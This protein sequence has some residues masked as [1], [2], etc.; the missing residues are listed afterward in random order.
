MVCGLD[1]MAS[2]VR[3]AA[4]I[5]LRVRRARVSVCEYGHIANVSTPERFSSLK[6]ASL[7][8]RR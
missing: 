2:I 1:E 4:R 3:S 6:Y 7:F 5:H 8:G